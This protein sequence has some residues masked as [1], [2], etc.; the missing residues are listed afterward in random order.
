MPSPKDSDDENVFNFKPNLKSNQTNSTS[1]P[2]KIKLEP[3]TGQAKTSNV[4]P[5]NNKITNEN[6]Q[7]LDE[8]CSSSVVA[9]SGDKNETIVIDESEPLFDDCPETFCEKI[10]LIEQPVKPVES[11]SENDQNILDN[12]L[13]SCRQCKV[14]SF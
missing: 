3:L 2:Q 5:S 13:L 8:S 4:S 12:H 1:S 9:L 7:K 6:S 11:K 14:V 10:E